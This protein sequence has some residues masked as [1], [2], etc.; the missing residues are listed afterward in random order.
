MASDTVPVLRAPMRARELDVP[1]GA[2]AEFGL[3]HGLVGIAGALSLVPHA[4]EA[5]LDR[6]AEER[7]PK[8]AA[9]VRRF[10]A[11][12]DGVFVWTRVRDG[13]FR[14][15]R[16]DGPWRYEDSAAA[17]AVGIHHVRPAVWLEQPLRESDVPAGVARTFARGGR[18]LQRIHDADVER[19]TAEL[20]RSP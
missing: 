19:R 7:G 2:G 20:W 3:S 16:I 4:L 6:L 17:T 12:P 18:N 10:A 11:W 14:L 13:T 9:M 15:G 1:P 5:A 8:A